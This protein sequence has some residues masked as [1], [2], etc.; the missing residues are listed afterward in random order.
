MKTQ[1]ALL[2]ADTAATRNAL[3]HLTSGLPSGS[4]FEWGRFEHQSKI[5]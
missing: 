3:K 5:R 4:F 2:S 1:T